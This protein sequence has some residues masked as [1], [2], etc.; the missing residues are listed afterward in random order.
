VANGDDDFKIDGFDFVNQVIE[1]GF[2][3]RLQD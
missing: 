2:A 1:L 3:C